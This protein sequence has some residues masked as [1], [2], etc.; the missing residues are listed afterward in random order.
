RAL[1]RLPRPV[2]RHHVWRMDLIGGEQATRGDLE[3][4]RHARTV[5]GNIGRRIIGSKPGVEAGIDPLGDA[6]LTREEGMADALERAKRSGPEH[7]CHCLLAGLLAGLS[8]IHTLTPRSRAG[9]RALGP[10]PRWL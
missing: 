5:L 4:R 9:A 10:P 2:D 6:A 1:V 3:R 8:D 7:A